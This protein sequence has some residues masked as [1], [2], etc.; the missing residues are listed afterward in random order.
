MVA[1]PVAYGAQKRIRSQKVQGTVSQ[2]AAPATSAPRFLSRRDFYRLLVDGVAWFLGLT[3]A[4]ACPVRLHDRGRRVL[5]VAGFAVAAILLQFLIGHFLHLY[6]G[7]YRYGSFDEVSGLSAAVISVG[8][9]LTAFDYFAFADRAVPASTPLVGSLVALIL[10]FA[11]RYV[12]RY[13]LER[14]LRPDAETATKALIF[15]AGDGGTQVVQSMIRDPHSIY[16]PVGMLDDNPMLAEPSG[17]RRSR[18][19]HPQRH[20]RRRRA[21]TGAT[22]LII[23]IAR[24]NAALIRDVNAIASRRRVWPSRWCRRSARSSTAKISSADIRDINEADLLGRHQIETDLDSIAHYLRGKRVLVTGRRRLD[25]LRAVPA[26][27]PLRPG[28]ADHAR[29]R[30]VGPARGSAVHCTAA[31]CSTTT[32][33]C[34][35]TSATQTGCRQV[36]EERRPEVV[37]HAAALKHLP[38][39]EKYPAEAVKTN[40]WGTLTV[41]RAAQSI[42][43]DHVREHLDRQGRQPDQRPGLLEAD[44]RAAHRSDRCRDRR[45]DVPERAVRQRPRQPRIGAHCVLEPDRSRRP[46]HGHRPRRH[47]VLHDRPRGRAAGHPGRRHRSRRRGLVLDM[48][49][50]VRIADV[51]RQLASQSPDPIEI[52][53]TGLRPGEKLD[54]DLFGDGEVDDRPI[55]PL[56]SHVRVPPLLAGDALDLPVD[57]ETQNVRVAGRSLSEPE[58]K[59]NLTLTRS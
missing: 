54:E 33:L 36:F 23:A 24:A 31:H 5:A 4:A 44:R 18:H 12:W 2:T 57:G 10:M 29:P 48:G 35:P 43:V 45:R 30:R 46:D 14:S 11:V 16:L 27:L 17:Q 37:F 9:I 25:R 52:V 8:L 26:D 22:T 50:P 56:I 6:R 21:K 58:G 41:L 34:L 3:F 51:A 39:L 59:P 55:H 15:G 32:A 38:L 49:E 19:G 40:V 13:M 53:Y 42:G 20:R 7:R 1:V 47:P 28:R